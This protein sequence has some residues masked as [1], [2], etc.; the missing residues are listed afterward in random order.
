MEPIIIDV[1]DKNNYT[2]LNVFRSSRV[3]QLPSPGPNLANRRAI[4]REGSNIMMR[5]EK[6]R[7]I[8]PRSDNVT[9]TLNMV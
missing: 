3:A 5:V 7:V 8:T 2:I 1:P 4:T 6:V 9:K